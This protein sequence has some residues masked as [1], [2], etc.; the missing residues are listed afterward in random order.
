M[1]LTLD[2]FTD[3]LTWAS[4]NGSVLI[5][6]IRT[7]ID[8][9]LVWSLLYYLIEIMRRNIRTLQIFKGVMLVI[10]VKL[11][12]NVL[13]LNM[14]SWLVDLILN[15]G[16]VALIIVFQPEVRSML[17]R[18]GQTRVINNVTSL[19]SSDKG[20]LVNQLYEACKQMSDEHTGA[21]ISFE[22]EQS[23]MDYIASGVEI[24][25]KVN[26]DLLLT[27]FME[28]TRLH[29][30]AVIIQGNRICCASAFFPQTHRELSP[31]YGAR[32]RAALGVSEV[33]DALTIVVS[34]ETGRVSFAIRGE[35]IPVAMNDFK[36]LLLK[37]I[38]GFISNSD[39]G[40]EANG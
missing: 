13:S 14:V 18:L 32:H 28:G 12:S 23:L 26:S 3:I 20:Q 6:T 39:N 10:F 15:W 22:R 25:A 9:I 7:I 27:I 24:D 30:G 8:I 17:E 40:G 29:D 1:S 2:V 5:S 34:E 36:N 35:L 16:V 4:G 37:E 11:I 21:L 31:K 19:S 38:D 33:T